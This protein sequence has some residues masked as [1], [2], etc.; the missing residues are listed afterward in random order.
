MRNFKF[1]NTQDTSGLVYH[2]P[3]TDGNSFGK[4]V[5]GC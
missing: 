3:L 1:Y 2:F 4:D 5:M